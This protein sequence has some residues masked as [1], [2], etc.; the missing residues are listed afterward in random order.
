MAFAV[1][2]VLPIRLV[3]LVVVRDKITQREAVVGNYEVDRGGRTSVGM[4]IEVAG[5]GDTRGKLRKRRWL[6]T[7]EVAY[8]V[9]VLSVPF[10]P[11]RRKVADLIATIA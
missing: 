10:A 2:A 11:Q 5:S 7:P 6:S 9:A 1:I 4:F 8:G 3:V